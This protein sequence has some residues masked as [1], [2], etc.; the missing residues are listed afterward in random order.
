MVE[1]IRDSFFLARSATRER[2][3]SNYSTPH[4][5]DANLVLLCDTGLLAGLHEFPTRADVQDAESPEQLRTI[6]Q[7][8]LRD[9]LTI[10]PPPYQPSTSKSVPSEN[11]DGIGL[12]IT[13]VKPAGD[14]LHVFSHI[15]K[16]YRVQWILLEGA[17]PNNTDPGKPPKLKPNYTFASAIATT[18]CDSKTSKKK[19]KTEKSGKVRTKDGET[20]VPQT[21]N[22]PNEPGLRWVQFDEVKDAKYVSHAC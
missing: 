11:Q 21:A 12:R 7:E 22:K 19:G 8:V 20:S 16:T 5:R 10:P 15:R 13:K 1:S 18:E 14:V 2:S 4:R 17:S 9:V 3:V 6:G